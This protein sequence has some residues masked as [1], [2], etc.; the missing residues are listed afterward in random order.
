MTRSVTRGA[1]P[2]LAAPMQTGDGLLARLGPAGP[3]PLKALAGLCAA[4]VLADAEHPLVQ[5]KDL[6]HGI[7]A[8]LQE[9]N[10][11]VAGPEY[12]CADHD[13][14]IA[15]DLSAWHA[16]RHRARRLAFV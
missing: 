2:G 16:E 7:R 3:M 9:Q 14:A 1:C 13:A 8:R 4:R 6:P 15:P 5:S 12:R 11:F 10:G